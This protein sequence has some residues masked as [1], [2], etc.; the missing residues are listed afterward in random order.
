MR[1]LSRQSWEEI[2]EADKKINLILKKFP[3]REEKKK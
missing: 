2:H 3:S 1:Q